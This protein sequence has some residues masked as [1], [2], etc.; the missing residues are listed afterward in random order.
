MSLS[1]LSQIIA[2]L[3]ALTVHEFSHAFMANKL[4]DPT[5]KYSGRLSLNPIRHID[6]LGTVLLPLVLLISRSPFVFGWAKPVPVNTYNLRGKYGELWVSLAGPAANFLTAAII[7]MFLRFAPPAMIA[8]WTTDFYNLFIFILWTNVIIGVFNLIP[9]PPLDGSKIILSLLPPAYNHVRDFITQYG[10][11]FLM[12][13]ILFGSRLLL[14]AAFL[15]LR[16][17]GYSGDEI[18]DIIRVVSSR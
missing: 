11:L 2:F 18:M 14:L 9:I 10:I 12:A 7:A 1:V 5:A 16:L 13:F 15:V 8:S 3:V 4:G 6:L 17:L